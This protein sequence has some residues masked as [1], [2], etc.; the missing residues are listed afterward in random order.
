MITNRRVSLQ[1]LALLAVAAWSTSRR[2]CSH[3][4]LSSPGPHATQA[5]FLKA[6]FSCRRIKDCFRNPA[7]EDVVL[8]VAATAA[9]AS[10]HGAHKKQVMAIDGGANVG[11][12][13]VHILA[14]FNSSA[15]GGQAMRI[16]VLAFEPVG[17]TSAK[18]KQ[19]YAHD[20]RVQVINAA[21]SDKD[22]EGFITFN[23]TGDV[24][25]SLS[26]HRQAINTAPV[27]LRALSSVAAEL[28]LRNLFLVKLDVESFEFQALRGMEELLQRQQVPI[29]QWERNGYWVKAEQLKHSVKDEVDYVA[30]FGYAVFVVGKRLIRVDSRYWNP[31]FDPGFADGLGTE[32]A[33][34]LTS[35][36]CSCIPWP[37]KRL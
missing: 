6:I 11:G 4:T 34:N 24:G 32:W 10:L 35:W 17:E 31:L 21:L 36:L 7:G 28:R 27:V 23:S 29:I 12:Y 14:A 2:N 33:L 16:S 37:F 3:T 9:C 15:C 22:G 13:T 26:G 30:N 20:G 5:D 19:R 1:V 25:A 8:D 18:L